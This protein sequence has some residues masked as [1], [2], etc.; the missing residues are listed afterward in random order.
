MAHNIKMPKFI[1]IT[2]GVVSSLGK[3]LSSAALGAILQSRGY[4]VKL[5]K[6]DPYLNID[7]GTMNPNQ[8]GEV[9]VT[10]DGAETDLD[11][12]HYERFT[13]TPATKNDNITAGRIY[14]EV[15]NN[16]R[17]GKYLGGTVQVIPHV[18]EQIKLFISHGVS[19]FD[20]V[21]I[22]VGGTVGDIE[23]LPFLEAIRQFGNS[24][25]K[26]RA[27]Y[28]HLTLVP[29][30]EAASE[31]KTKP[32]QHSVKELRG[33]GIQPDILLCRC[34]RPISK[35][36]RDKIAL[37]CNLDRENVIQA[38][39]ASTIYEVPTMYSNEGL[40]KKVLE[41]FDIKRYKKHELNKWKEIVYKINNPTHTVSI[42]IVGK[43][44]QLKDAY[45]SLLEALSH[46][47]I[48]NNTKVNIVWIDAE[49]INSQNSYLK[50]NKLDGV[51]VPG[52]FGE[53]GSV[54]KIAAIKF[55]REN[56]IPFMGICFGM[57]LAVVEF[58][59]NVLR[60]KDVGSSELG[61]YKNDIVGLLTEWHKGKK[62]ISRDKSSNIGGTMRLG[63][64]RC[65][66]TK[67]T[68]AHKIY[69]KLSISERHRHRYEVNIKYKELL[70][71]SGAI[72]SGC[73][74]DGKLPEIIEIPEHPWFLGVQ[75]HPELSSN[76]L[77]ANPLFVSFVK[78]SN[79]RYKEKHG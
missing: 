22:E 77:R 10:E 79:K 39:D 26:N 53:R 66:V 51:I 1:F 52:G 41:C 33:I 58:A 78:A 59:R 55:A 21:L 29:Y 74:P 34:E 60:L 2:G 14:Q 56:N 18:T 54:G 38:M 42:G 25:G 71:K 6:L 46:G 75:F 36:D 67:G 5:R 32:T 73:S 9:L 45:K 64:Y 72:I 24:L 50:L 65:L 48:N 7:P 57:Q 62:I 69:K 63:S 37:F 35:K 19:S 68:K 13:G 20:F 23:S 47:G 15:L 40:D 12:G 44:I 76:P 27:I 4:K 17:K 3:G 43:Y 16:E 61:K 11:L 70:E 8:H 31:Q 49:K 28:I 30:L